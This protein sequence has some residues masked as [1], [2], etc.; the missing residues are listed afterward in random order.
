M[1]DLGIAAV[2]SFLIPGVGQIYNRRFLRAVFW[3]I[4]T[5]GFWIGTGRHTGVDLPYWLR[6]HGL[7]LCQDPAAKLEAR[8]LVRA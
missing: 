3:L 7:F 2:L 6:L 4:I 5:P 1:K 8:Y